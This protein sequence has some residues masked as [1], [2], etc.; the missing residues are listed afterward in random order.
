VRAQLITPSAAAAR[1]L[2]AIASAGLAACTELAPHSAGTP[3]G[4]MAIAALALA[5]TLVALLAQSEWLSELASSGPLV[6]RAV[7]LRRKSWSAAFQRQLNPDA[8]GHARPRAPSAA[9][10]A[11]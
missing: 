7:A 1:Y 4:L 9:P 8:P 10:A 6:G 5:A 2:L 3:S 11:A